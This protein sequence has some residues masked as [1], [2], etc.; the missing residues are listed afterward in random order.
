[1]F[2]HMSTAALEVDGVEVESPEELADLLLRDPYPPG[3]Y[4]QGAFSLVTATDEM[5]RRSSVR[6]YILDTLNAKNE[7]GSP[8]YA[9][10]LSTNSL[11][12]RVLFD[13]EGSGSDDVPMANGVEYMVGE[14]LY[15]ADPRYDAASTGE[16]KTVAA[17]REVIVSGGSFNTPQILKLSGVGP[18]EEL[19]SLEIPVVADVPGVV[20]PSFRSE[21]V[22]TE[23]SSGLL[24]LEDDHIVTYRRALSY[25]TTTRPASS[26]THQPNGKT[27]QPTAHSNSTP[28]TPASTSGS[29]TAQDPT[30][31]PPHRSP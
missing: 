31:R 21:D 29:T 19:E 1:M 8:K 16:L 22:P 24:Y 11:A 13:D 5:K 6:G 9:L 23:I 7:D 27:T 4:S 30:A 3:E 25:K 10:T 18:R 20:S 26:S 14:A 15:A 17:S 2:R 12:T 28:R